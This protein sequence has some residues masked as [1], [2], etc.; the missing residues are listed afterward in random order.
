MPPGAATVPDSSGTK[1]R[2]VIQRLQS[3]YREYPSRFWILVAATF[4]DA[5][6]RTIL[7]PFF[8]LYITDR[9]GVGMT[10]AG[11]LFSVFS[12]SGFAGNMLGG[13]LTDRFGRKGMVLFG[14]VF[15]ALS[16][17]TMGFAGSLSAFYALAI[18][19]G[20]LSDIAGPARGAM[21]ADLLPEHQRAE[22]FGI[23]RVA[24]NMAWIIGPTIG[25]VLASRSYLL[26]F[27]LDAVGS[28]ITA[29]ILFR[30]LPETRPEARQTAQRESIGM[31]FAGYFKAA[32]DGTFM[33]FVLIAALMNL[34]YLQMYSTLSVFLRD[35]H[36]V[37]TQGYGFL[38]SA[39]AVLVVLTQFWVTR[40]IKPY[41]PMIMMAVGTALYMIGFSAYGFVS[42]YG[43]FLAAM[44]IITVGEMI[45]MPVS[46]ALVA[47]LAPADMRGRYIAVS[48]L[49]WEIPSAIG[50]LAAGL[51]LDNYNP[52]L[53]WY[54]GGV[55]ALI[56]SIGFLVLHST[57]HARL[58]EPRTAPE[59]AS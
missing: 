43:A 12:V 2:R 54:A 17:L 29:A 35:V 58:A 31:T 22:G 20:V 23:L 47:H 13:A 21:V 52:N 53:V 39:N 48:G 37:P 30:M 50:P 32:A 40:R 57:A 9:F 5:V 56:A 18:L 44:L 42:S 49:S 27:I 15:S 45:V 14:L 24:G 16:S 28:L 25:G 59:A 33:A 1:G 55:L 3:T 19:V 4:I 6:G 26:L 51:I 10:E 8:A 34:V 36:S 7:N 41:P 38:M 46:N 11:L